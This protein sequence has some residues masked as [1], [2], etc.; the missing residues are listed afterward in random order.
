M[1]MNSS[2]TQEIIPLIH[3]CVVN[4]IFPKAHPKIWFSLYSFSWRVSAIDVGINLDM[5]HRNILVH[6]VHELRISLLE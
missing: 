6:Y 3:F 4:A 2:I 1:G 5:V